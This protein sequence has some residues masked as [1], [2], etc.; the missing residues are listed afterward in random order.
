LEPGHVQ[1]PA[2]QTFGDVVVFNIQ[3]SF[4]SGFMSGFQKKKGSLV[5]KKNGM[6]FKQK[7]QVVLSCAMH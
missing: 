1:F 4:M 5:F 2:D 6:V 7:M 3:F